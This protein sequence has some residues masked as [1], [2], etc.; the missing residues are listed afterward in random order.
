MKTTND[1]KVLDRVAY[2]KG[3]SYAAKKMKEKGKARIILPSSLAY[4]KVGSS[5]VSP[6]TSIIIDME[7][8]SRG[9]K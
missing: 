4:G 7:I 5:S 8:K 9:T 6:Y 1:F 2:L 3:I